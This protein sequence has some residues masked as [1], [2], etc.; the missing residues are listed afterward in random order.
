MLYHVI[1]FLI[2]TVLILF[3]YLLIFHKQMSFLEIKLSIAWVVSVGLLSLVLKY[4]G[5]LPS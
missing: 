3:P 4:T 1:E 2:L 5:V